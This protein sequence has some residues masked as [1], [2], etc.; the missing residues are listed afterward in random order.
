MALPL[1]VRKRIADHDPVVDGRTVKQFCRDEGI[2]R[3][4][5]SNIKKRIADRGRAGLLPD[6]TAPKKPHRVYD[7]TV[8]AA[9]VDAR[10]SLKCKGMDY[11]PWSIYYYLIDTVGL[12]PAPSRATI[13]SKLAQLGLAEANARKRP[14]KSYRRFA[15]DNANELWQIDGLVYRLFDVAHTQVTIYQLI[16]DATRFD[17]GSLAYPNSENGLDARTTLTTAFAAYGVPQEV[18]SDN[19]EAFATYHRGSLSVTEQWLASQGVLA[20]A[21]WAPTTQGKDERSHQTLIKYLDART[22]TTIH[23]VNTIISDYRNWYNHTRR[24]QSLIVNKMHITPGQAW[25]SWPRASP[26][27]T[28]ISE[29]KQWE[30]IAVFAP[31]RYLTRT[32]IHQVGPVGAATPTG[33]TA[34]AHNPTSEVLAADTTTLSTDPPT[35]QNLWGIAEEIVIDRWGCL[36]ITGTRLYI[37]TRYKNRRVNAHVSP[38][39]IAEFFTAHD[40]EFL[41]SVPLPLVVNKKSTSQLNINHVK[42]FQHRNPPKL[43]PNLSN[44]RPKRGTSTTN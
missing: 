24:H 33:T 22:P 43:M 9:I 16:D 4:T 5:Y 42:G 1:S 34:S 29:E 2:S 26:P 10:K 13:A 44:P 25:E 11:G 12:H 23:E 40:G 39:D 32:E 36:S 15:R 8:A 17:V 3:Q 7:D 41:F 28:P 20:I 14:R 38:D 19:G 35:I 37:G 30:R 27:T 6:S 21:G 18:L 31:E